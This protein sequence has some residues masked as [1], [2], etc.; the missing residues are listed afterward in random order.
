MNVEGVASGEDQVKVLI[1]YE[2]RGEAVPKS[3]V[4]MC[5]LVLVA[6]VVASFMMGNIIPL[7]ITG[8]AAY[9]AWHVSRGLGK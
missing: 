8:A 7:V 1:R 5:L 3:F 9:A 2:R 6:G 4:E